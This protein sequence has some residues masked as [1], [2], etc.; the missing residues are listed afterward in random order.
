MRPLSAAEL[1]GA[2]ERGTGEH[3]LDRALTLLS[4]WSGE[5]RSELAA[6]AIGQRDV[7]LIEV[8]EDIFGGTLEGFAECP[9]CGERLEYALPTRSLTAAAPLDEILA[10]L[11]VVTEEI[12]LRVHPP[13]SLDVAAL[14]DCNDLQ[15]A[16]RRLAERCIT[17][18][19]VNGNAVSPQAVPDS[20]LEL[21]SERL[22]AAD[23]LAEMLI[24]LTC[25]VCGHQWQVIFDIESFLW[26]KISA[27]AKRLLREVH[28][29]AQAYGWREPDI[30]ALSPAR[31][32][33][34]M[35]MVACQTF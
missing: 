18:A 8:H 21:L 4:A 26:T 11:S 17:E 35:E 22:A 1:I 20:V 12:T 15:T 23:P 30:L 6:L 33:S 32:Q 27:L 9:Q 5:P 34:Y 2:W 19:F 29:L 3:P 13:S 28:V 31:R 25:S 24:D 7:R 10:E 14:T 16:H